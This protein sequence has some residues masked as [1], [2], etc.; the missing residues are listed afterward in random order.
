MRTDSLLL[1][2]ITLS[3]LLLSTSAQSVSG[4]THFVGYGLPGGKYELIDNYA[5]SIFLQKFNYYSGP[6]PTYGHVQ[7]VPEAVAVQNGYSTTNPNNVV[8]SVDTTNRFPRGGP[9]RPSVRLISDN[10]YTHGLFILDAA[11]MPWGCGTWPAFWLLGPNWPYNGEV[12]IIEG[13][14]TSNDNSMSLHTSAGC[15][16]AGSGATGTFQTSNCDQAANGNTGCGFRANRAN[17]PN[18]FGD[19]FNSN[20]GG[21][22]VTEWTSNY[23]QIWFFPRNRIPTSI[24]QGAPNIT[25]FGQPTALFQGCNIDR[26]FNNHSMVINTD[27]CGS[28]AGNVYNQFPNCPQNPS[29]S[30]WDACVDYVGNNPQAFQDAY[31][32][33][34]SIQVYQM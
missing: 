9:G 20:G 29:I 8:L 2:Q 15:T 1:R 27:F 3:Y 32:Q 7:Y 33:I 28:W 14:H 11:H 23:I 24:S 21:M 17:N 13:V 16:I 10:T 12:D 19:E 22:Y 26:Y 34:N 5:P 18:N 30:G 31:W 25:E 6:D 4:A